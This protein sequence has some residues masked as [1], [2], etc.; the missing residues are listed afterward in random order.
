MSTKFRQGQKGQVLAQVLSHPA[1]AGGPS[2]ARGAAE[3]SR[4]CWGGL[5]FHAGCH[6]PQGIT[7]FLQTHQELFPR[8]DLLNNFIIDLGITNTTDT[9]NMQRLLVCILTNNSNE[10]S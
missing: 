9:L 4:S 1:L 7:S 6:V 2:R 3:R 5:T 8:L 10:S